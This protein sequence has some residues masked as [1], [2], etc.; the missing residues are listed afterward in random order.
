[1]YTCMNCMYLFV[2]VSMATPPERWDYKLVPPSLAPPSLKWVLHHF[3]FPCLSLGFLLTLLSVFCFFS[4]ILM[5]SCLFIEF[6]NWVIIFSRPRVLI[7]FSCQHFPLGPLIFLGI[8]I[9][10][11]ISKFVS[12]NSN[13]WLFFT[14]LYSY[15]KLKDKQTKSSCLFKYL[16]YF[17]LSADIRYKTLTSS[18][19]SLG[20]VIFLQREFTFASSVGSSQ[21]LTVHRN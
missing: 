18:S 16:N 1:M 2:C 11:F 20:D 21:E 10:G 14:T 13:V 3:V 9:I 5:R 12:Y 8:L 19:G 17:W 6:E 4:W 7:C 15:G